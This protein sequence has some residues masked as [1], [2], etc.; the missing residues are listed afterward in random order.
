MAEF[1]EHL[2]IE[3]AQ[4]GNLDAFNWLVTRYQDTV[5]SLCFR[6]MSDPAAAD[7]L[8]QDAFIAAYQKLDTY[9]GGSFKSWI[10]RIAANL[11]LDE[12]RRRKRQRTDNIDDLMPPDSADEPPIPSN[13]ATPE[14][15]AEQVEL[16]SAIQRCI[17]GLGEDQRAVLVM[18]DVEGYA[19]QEIADALN[20]QIGTVKSRLSRAR[21][22]MRRC[23]AGVMELLPPE[24]RP[25]SDD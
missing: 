12:L 4:R 17:S 21:L 13:D 19:Y 7:D 18:S 22:S 11:C 15:S 25:T 8:A 9:R 10:M 23:L 1:N 3:Q 20:T 6:M 5:Y 24:Y 2:V 14:E 16:A